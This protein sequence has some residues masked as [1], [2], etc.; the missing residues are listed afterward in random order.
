MKKSILSALVVALFLTACKDKASS[1]EVEL[2]NETDSLSYAIGVNLGEDF[3]KGELTDLNYELLLRGLNDVR[4]SSNVMESEDAQACIM[5]VLK[6]RDEKKS[7]E[8]RKE[9]EEFLATNKSKEGVQSTPSGLQYQVITEGTGAKPL[10]TDMVKVHY[11]G[12][13]IDGTVFDSSV[14]R[15]EPTS[16][17]LNQVIPGWTEGLQLMSVGSKYKFFIPQSLAYGPRDMGD[18]KPFST[19]IFEVE[20]LGIGE[21]AAE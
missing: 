12:T 20:L 1:G 11:H 10:P 3:A 14:D 4:D 19:L 2:K 9:G 13:L 17:R 7:A 8:A 21:T 16:F 5:S 15:G 18:I 6:G